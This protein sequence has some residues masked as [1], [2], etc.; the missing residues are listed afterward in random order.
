MWRV[1][2]DQDRDLIVAVVESWSWIHNL[3]ERETVDL[4][5]DGNENDTAC[6]EAISSL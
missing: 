5:F 1:A 6:A 3:V 4:E 2:K